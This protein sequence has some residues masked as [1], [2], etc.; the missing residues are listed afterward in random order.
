METII[1][2]EI[3]SRIFSNEA[4]SNIIMCGIVIYI[5]YML[6]GFRKDIKTLNSD[7]NLIKV[8][9]GISNVIELSSKENK[10]K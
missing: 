10:K 8:H 9:L 3:V 7:V 5:L 6:K 4:P 2:S 1:I